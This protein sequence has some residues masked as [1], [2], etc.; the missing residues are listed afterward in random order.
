MKSNTIEFV[1]RIDPINN[2]DFYEMI[3]HP[4]QRLKKRMDKYGKNRNYRTKKSFFD[5]YIAYLDWVIRYIDCNIKKERCFDFNNMIPVVFARKGVSEKQFARHISFYL[6]ACRLYL[7][8]LRECANIKA[9][10]NYPNSIWMMMADTEELIALN[11]YYVKKKRSR[12]STMHIGY[13]GYNQ[14]S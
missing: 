12:F 13:S 14:Y 10:V 3:L 11:E 2:Q 9:A 5:S 8:K 4:L 6:Y 7:I 1:K